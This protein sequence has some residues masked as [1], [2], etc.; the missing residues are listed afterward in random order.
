MAA[1][2]LWFGTETFNGKPAIAS[3]DASGLLQH[4]KWSQRFLI[5][6]PSHQQHIKTVQ[7][8]LNIIMADFSKLGLFLAFVPPLVHGPEALFPMF[9]RYVASYVLPPF[10]LEF[11]DPANAL[12][13]EDQKEMLDA[14]IEKAPPNKWKTAADYVFVVTFEQRQGASC[15]TSIMVASMYTLLLPLEQ[16]HPVHLLN[17]AIGSFMKLTT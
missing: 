13:L 10:G 7:T 2:P 6:L 5:F 12:T 1:F 15:F 16:R 4:P 17:V 3:P 9:A 11:P 14:A 8:L